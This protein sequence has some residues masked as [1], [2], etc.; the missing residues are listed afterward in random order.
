M[1]ASV[2]AAGAPSPAL[3][4]RCA[5]CHGASGNT[6]SAALYPNLAGQSAAYIELQLNK[7]AAASGPMRRCAPARRA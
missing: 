4:Q 2:A 3:L 5:A 7:S 6:A 1:L